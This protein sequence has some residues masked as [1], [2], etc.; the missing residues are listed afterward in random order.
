MDL[1]DYLNNRDSPQQKKKYKHVKRKKA[2]WCTNCGKYG[3]GYRRCNETVISLRLICF[4][5]K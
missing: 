5:I 1:R 2:H 4:R 3:H